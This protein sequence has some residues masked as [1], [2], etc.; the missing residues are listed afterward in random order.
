MRLRTAGGFATPVLAMMVA[1]LVLALAGVS[2]DLSRVVTAQR[3]LSAVTDSAASAGTGGLDLEA[4]YAGSADELV[5]D[6]RAATELACSYLTE[7]F[8]DLVCPGPYAA[9]SVE[10]DSIRVEARVD[11]GLS[12]LRLLLPATGTQGSVEVVAR[13]EASAIRV[14]PR[15]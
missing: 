14:P 11:V 10:G 8:E 15:P 7:A 4:L 12:L 2:I 5:L 9:V 6:E 1:L 13:S 3:H